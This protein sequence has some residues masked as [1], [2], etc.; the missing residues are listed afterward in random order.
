MMRLVGRSILH[1]FALHHPDARTAV[2]G[3]QAV[4]SENTFE[5]WVALKKTFN[6]VDKVGPFLV[7][8]LCGN[9]YRLIARVHFASQT[10]RVVAVLT[11]QEYDR[12]RWRH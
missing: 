2:S 9:K 11:H 6:S 5:H 4:V 12:A 10:I 1:N 8:N 3:W 7:F